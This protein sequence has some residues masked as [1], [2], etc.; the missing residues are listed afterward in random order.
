M[1]F[2]P[3]ANNESYYG[4]TP[5]NNV[6]IFNSFSIVENTFEELAIVRQSAYSLA[7]H[8]DFWTGAERFRTGSREHHRS[9]NDMS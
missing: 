1:V 4:C 9:V 8:V 2:V 7:T 5:A 3:S 6:V